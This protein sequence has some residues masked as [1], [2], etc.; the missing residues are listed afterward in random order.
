MS[1]K[2]SSPRP[3]AVSDDVYSA[4]WAAIF[5]DGARLGAEPASKARNDGS[6]PSAPA[7]PEAVGKDA[8]VYIDN[9]TG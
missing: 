4:N 3:F 2:G 1:G 9:A 8:P 7:I 5:P 6:I